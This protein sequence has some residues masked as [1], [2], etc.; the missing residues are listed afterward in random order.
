MSNKHPILAESPTN[1]SKPIVPFLFLDTNSQDQE[2]LQ[3]CFRNACSK[4]SIKSAQ[5]LLEFGADA[6]SVDDV[7]GRTCL[8]IGS[9]AGHLE[10]VVLLT[11]TGNADLD[12]EDM[13]GRRALHYAAMGGYH[14]IVSYLLS[15]GA[16]DLAIDQD[17]STPLVYAVIRGHKVCVEAFLEQGGQNAQCM[18]FP[19]F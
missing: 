10:I 14:Q 19:C 2:W 4:G 18:L 1:D 8:H 6:R 5:Y 15:K 11:E 12:H 9:M 16:I 17:G 7:N 3:R 13:S